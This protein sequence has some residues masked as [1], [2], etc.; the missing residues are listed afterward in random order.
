MISCNTPTRVLFLLALMQGFDANGQKRFSTYVGLSF[1]GKIEQQFACHKPDIRP[2]IG[3]FIS[4]YVQV[5][6]QFYLGLEAMTSGPAFTYFYY[7][8]GGTCA[9]YDPTTNTSTFSFNNLN[10]IH[11]IL[12]SQFQL[13]SKETKFQPYIG[14]GFGNARYKFNSHDEFRDNFVVSPEVGMRAGKIIIATH[15]FLGGN[16][17]SFLKYDS[18]SNRNVKMESV[19]SQL[20]YISVS[21]R[22]VQF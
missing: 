6:S 19:N 16:T 21:H 15:M 8:D 10:T 3:L 4:Q 9:P 22:L 12:R 20:F 1:G 11:L 13:L 14:L 18:F 17:P 2:R 7:G 5:S